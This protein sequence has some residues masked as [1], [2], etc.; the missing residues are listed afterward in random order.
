LKLWACGY[1]LYK[2]HWRKGG[3]SSQN[4]R[5][6]VAKCHCEDRWRVT[7]LLWHM[8]RSS[9]GAFEDMVGLTE[10]F[11]IG[12]LP[13]SGSIDTFWPIRTWMC[14]PVF[15]THLLWQTIIS[16]WF[17]KWNRSYECVVSR[18]PLKFKN[19]RCLRPG[20]KKSLLGLL[21][22]VTDTPS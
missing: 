15:D 12:F 21:P 2:S 19:N 7:P 10:V 14:S 9:E 20:C 3:E 13:A 6:R 17:R 11:F 18:M 1:S 4:R 5:R 8:L 22:A 16:S